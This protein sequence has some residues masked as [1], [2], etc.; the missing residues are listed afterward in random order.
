V[1]VRA[2]ELLV[3]TDRRMAADAGHDLAEVIAAAVDAGAPAVVLREKDLPAAERHDLAVRLRAAT[4][5]AAALIVAGDPALARAVGA[6]G[7]HLAA[8]DI[9]PGDSAAG[10][11][12]GRSCHTLGEL[13][14][15]AMGGVAAYA[16][17]SPV[18]ATASK[19]AYGPALGI[20][21]LAAGCRAVAG[22]G[23]P[24]AVYALGGIGPAQAGACLAA[25]AAGVAV[26]GAV[27]RAD[28]PRGIVRAMICE[29]DA[30]HP[31]RTC[32]G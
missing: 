15:T 1:T 22:V 12:V 6:D 20:D 27:M 2:P 10:L 4:A 7:V 9:W 25:G 11:R 23:S 28:D 30:A 31:T 24:L 32:R 19:P 18:F 17:F 14:A 26:M 29:L 3:L 21:R 5:G 13:M 16:T 8:A